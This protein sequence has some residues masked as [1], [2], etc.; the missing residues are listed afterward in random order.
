[1][2][3]GSFSSNTTTPSSNFFTVPTTTQ[4]PSTSSI[5]TNKGFGGFSFGAQTNTS[6]APSSCFS[7][8]TTTNT[9][10]ANSTGGGFNFGNTSNTANTGGGFS[11]G[12]TS[13]TSGTNNTSGGFSFG[14]TPNTNS[15][16]NGFNFGNTSNISGTNNTSGGFSF[17]NP[18]NTSNININNS[19]FNFGSTGNTINNI[20][21]IEQK[22]TYQVTIPQSLLY[23]TVS[24]PGASIHEML[25]NK[26]NTLCRKQNPISPECEL[27]AVFYNKVDP[28]Y[29]PQISRPPHARIDLWELGVRENPNP[30]TLAPCIV[31]GFEELGRRIIEQIKAYN[32]HE[33][34]LKHLHSIIQ[35]LRSKYATSS[36]KMKMMIQKQQKVQQTLLKQSSKLLLVSTKN[37]PLTN[38]ENELYNKINLLNNELCQPHGMFEKLENFQKILHTTIKRPSVGIDTVSFTSPTIENTINENTTTIANTND[39]NQISRPTK[40]INTFTKTQLHDIYLILD[41]QSDMIKLM[42]EEQMNAKMTYQAIS[43]VLKK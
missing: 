9:A 10:G 42:L 35:E 24:G 20:T 7:F 5:N 43:D 41:T 4:Q 37:V 33:A 19:G 31:I 25:L 11:F 38:K 39:I 26:I 12:N 23:P 1:M 16:S 21:N 18:S 29:L 34:M 13:N 2:N 27:Q 32:T 40:N 28:I 3:F 36:Q 15:T 17:G 6:S 22:P 30:N 8:G 14:N